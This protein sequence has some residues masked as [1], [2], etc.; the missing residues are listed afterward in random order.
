MKRTINIFLSL[1]FLLAL[2]AIVEPAVAQ[3]PPHPPS[4]GHGQLGNQNPGGTSAPIDG[5]LSI[6]IAMGAAFG[7]RRFYKAQATADKK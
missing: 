7:T 4:T 2:L 6:L 5:G 1:I 3:E